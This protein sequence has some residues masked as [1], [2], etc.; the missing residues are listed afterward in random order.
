MA[1]LPYLQQNNPV[2]AEKPLNLTQLSGAIRLKAS[3]TGTSQTLHD[4]L[5]L[6]T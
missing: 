1:I 5:F 6:S 4:A 2:Q 3:L